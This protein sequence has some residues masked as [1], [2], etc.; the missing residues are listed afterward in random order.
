MNEKTYRTLEYFKI[1]D[2]L[3]NHTT[4][5]LSQELV[6][7]LRPFITLFEVNDALNQTH[8]AVNMM[9]KRGSPPISG[10]K[11]IRGS[12]KRC[13]IGGTLG[14]KELL[15]IADSL[16]IARRLK[17]YAS[18]DRR[19]EVYD[20]L[21][22]LFGGLTA[23]KKLEDQIKLSILSEDEIADSASSELA[24]LRRQMRNLQAKVKEILQ[25]MIH[26][27]RYQKYLQ[28]AL[29]TM[30]GD[31]YVIPVKAEHK[32]D[33]AG[34]V[35]DASATGATLFIEPMA[36]VETNNQLRQLKAKEEA[37]IER[38]LQELSGLVQEAYDGILANVKIITHLDFMFAK[39]KL[40]L[41]MDA[42]KPSMN[43]QGILDVK[44]ARHPLIDRKVVVATD[45]YLG[46]TFDTLIITGPNTGGKTVT[47]K[48]I[49]LFTLM[50]QAGL[51][52]PA[53]DG[54]VLAVFDKVFADI[55]DEQSIEQSLSTFSSHMTNIVHI[56][57][58]ASDNSLTL[59]DELGAGT[60]PVEG[61]ALAITILEYLHSRGIRT[62]ATTHY[63]ELKFFALAT[64]GI[65]NAACEFD[66]ETLRPTYKLLIGV[67][68]KS[69]AF[70]ISRRL[71]LEE[72]F[73]DRASQLLSKDTIE[74][75]DIL[76]NL[77]SNRQAAQAAREK[78]ARDLQETERLRAQATLD[79]EKFEQQKEKILEQARREA[80]KI[81]EQAK[82]TTEQTIKELNNVKAMADEKERNLGIEQA[83]KQLNRKLSAVEQS[84]AQ[85]LLPTRENVVPPTL[86]KGDD[87]TIVSLNQRAKV[88]T[89]PDAHGNAKVQAGIMQINVHVSNLR[90][91]E[92]KPT[93]QRTASSGRG[94]IGISKAAAAVVEVDVR[95]QMLDE[96]LEN[97]EKFLD[98]AMLA[99]LGQV[100]IIHGKGTGVLRNG[101]QQMLR[102]NRAI[103]SYRLGKYGEGDAG[104]TI[105]EL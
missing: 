95:G 1:L 20:I 52:V 3:K 103:K 83:R 53:A 67:P 9:V 6:D 92:Q 32:N 105:V 42:Y 12:L 104:V 14:A 96:A 19:E 69:N 48:T 63:S 47:I 18:E 28:D 80:K 98:D 37:E 15:H 60:D 13:E 73:I 39:A 89:L 79:I 56:L 55:G 71:G 50:A 16:T 44:K 10:L 36:V 49:G 33:V 31:R 72:H 65:E 78:S 21:D 38:I 62:A 102:N 61:A 27:N 54:S 91:I 5:V 77:E 51:F 88:I 97:V 40:S 74:F 85:S 101:I 70:A 29:V 25:T 68:G 94:A 7:E 17:Q 22:G 76:T 30:R 81:L 90:L 23:Y 57:S 86:K 100:S 59:F 34:L 93:G 58:E 35:H 99:G 82:E 24:H 87:V 43:D 8:Q 64:D 66:V 26:A 46:K 75:E 84:M 41:A 11:D 45:I 4:T 2:M